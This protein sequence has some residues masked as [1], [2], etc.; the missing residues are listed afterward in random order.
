M[1]NKTASLRTQLSYLDP[2]GILR[3]SEKLISANY[4]AQNVGSID[5][6]DAFLPATYAVPFGTIGVAATVGVI[7]NQ[8][9]QVLEVRLNGSTPANYT[10]PVGGVLAWGVPG[11]AA[12]GATPITSIAVKTT[13]TQSGDGY[14]NYWLFGDPT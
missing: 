1:P 9:G 13:A 6:P 5:V 10:I 7:E 8:T 4:Q 3:T 2:D 11:G 12:V 14:V